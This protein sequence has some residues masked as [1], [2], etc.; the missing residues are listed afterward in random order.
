MQGRAPLG[1]SAQKS[2]LI[3]RMWFSYCPLLPYRSKW[4]MPERWVWTHGISGLG[5]TENEWTFQA[6]WHLWQ[7]RQP[8]IVTLYGKSA[9]CTCGLV[10]LTKV[11]FSIC[12][13]Q[14]LGCLFFDEGHKLLFDENVCIKWPSVYELCTDGSWVRIYLMATLWLCRCSEWW[15]LA[16]IQNAQLSY[17]K[18]LSNQNLHITLFKSTPLNAK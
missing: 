2:S 16:L 18:Q 14:K 13:A 10:I 15:W 1:R 9:I 3:S 4:S 11:T 17:M 5:D 12:W 6:T 8:Q 7:R